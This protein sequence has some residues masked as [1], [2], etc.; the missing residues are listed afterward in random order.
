MN[1][2]GKLSQFHWFIFPLHISLAIQYI[3]QKMIEIREHITGRS[4]LGIKPDIH[5]QGCKQL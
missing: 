3:I 4:L 2:S 5:R 1:P